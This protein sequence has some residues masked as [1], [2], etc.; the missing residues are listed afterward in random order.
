MQNKGTLGSIVAGIIAIF[1]VLICLFYLSFSLVSSHYDGEADNWA[2][3][4]AG[5]MTEAKLAELN[6][7]KDSE[8]YEA[9]HQKIYNESRNKAKKTYIDN[10]RQQKVWLGYT[11]NDVQRWGVGLGLDLKGGMSVILQVSMPDMLNSLKTSEIDPDFTRSVA[12]A[13]SICHKDHSA[14]FVET[15]VETYRK[16][17]PTKDWSTVFA[18]AKANA[19]NDEIVSLIRSEVKDM[20]NTSATNVL[21]K[22]IDAFGVVSPNIQVLQGKDGQIM[23]E[24]PGVKEPERVAELLQ[25]SANLEFFKTYRDQFN[26]LI[27]SKIQEIH[28][29]LGKEGKDLLGK[30][31][32]RQ[33]IYDE[34][35][36]FT[37]K[38]EMV[39]GVSM[40][41]PVI[42]Y[43]N[44][45]DTAAVA[46]MLRTPQA[47]AL[48][49]TSVALRWEHTPQL[50]GTQEY[51]ALYALKTE[52]GASAM[53]GSY[54]T[55]AYSDYDPTHHNNYV[56][57]QMNSEG[58]KKWATL[59]G[60][61]VGYPVAIVLDGEVYSAPNVNDKITGGSS[62]ITGDFDIQEAK[63]LANVLK[64]G[65]MTA[66]VEIISQMVIGPSLGQQAIDAGIMSF[67]VALVL[68]MI[69][70]M[71]Y[72]GIIPGLIANGGLILNL[73]FTFGILASFQAVLT[74][75]GI[76]GIVLSL[77][78]AVDA[79]VL[80]FERAKEELRA[81]KNSRTAIQDGY[82]NAFSAI[83]DANLT[84]IITG[85]ILLAYGTG[86]IKGFATTLI[87]GIVCSF[88]TAVFLTR[89]VFTAC[90]KKKAFERLTFDT[91]LSRKMFVNSHIDFLAKWKK[92][93]VICCLFIAAVIASLF[94]RGLN[95]GID[96]SGG[97]NYVVQFDQDVNTVE[98]QE[99]L[100]P[101][102][103]GASVSVI[104]IDTPDKVRVST[105]YKIDEADGTAVE[106]EITTAL[107]EVLNGFNVNSLTAD[108]FSTAD[109]N[110]GIISSTKVGPTVAD[111]M[112]RDAYVAVALSLLAMFLYILL[113]FRNIAF[114]LG[115]LAAVAFTA[116][117][118]IGF[119][120][121]F[122]GMFPFAMEIDQA[123]IAAILTV[124]G[125][126]IND[127]VVVFD[128]VRENIGLFPK[129][130]FRE[131]VNLSIN[132]TLGRTIM[133]SGS[134][135]LVLLSIFCLGGDTLRSFV[136]AMIWGVV[137]GTL[138]T[139]FIASPV[140]YLADSR[141][142]KKAAAV[143]TKK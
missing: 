39:K 133:T 86:P 4:Q 30:S 47:L 85:I 118:I 120:S 69:L 130:S 93:A 48:L 66:R 21:R 71:S 132:Q 84:S 125:Y 107:Y 20:V 122:Y 95:P 25:R 103:E 1:L 75:S 9:V 38:F 131:M 94:I 2:R 110:H 105:N 62:Q 102:F 31:Y 46:A 36:N 87:I 68:L 106:K 7:S 138:A 74:L 27:A 81:G 121:F 98:I 136:F 65:K 143:P 78:M 73:F 91:T 57:M 116:F 70:M 23:L 12:I 41:N 59:T 16:A 49:P 26:Q 50:Q 100:A 60:E 45:A 14:D 37:G 11:Y 112:R 10:L 6:I 67:I 34:K 43:F 137:I 96:F 115:A 56:S 117:S 52:R 123:F 139:I 80:I 126:Q 108:E 64:S 128:R 18:K 33:P 92:S 19:T 124:I 114:S 55:D 15:F 35:G 127:T 119:Y 113:R 5:K 79:N 88:F 129:K 61:E 44:L 111:D 77:G 54:I 58:A 42:G 17:R 97:R 22:R 82:S 89:I 142:N 8:D 99:A 40:N 135:L 29:N 72:Y 134:T 140:A 51:Y 141:R 104:T 24:L 13:D 53:D 90:A 83:F 76:A 101:R 32:A 3:E 28:A 109:E 63:D